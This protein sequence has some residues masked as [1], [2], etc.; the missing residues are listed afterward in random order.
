[1]LSLVVEKNYEAITIQDITE[2][3]DLNRA[4]FYLHY[5]SKDELLVESLT[6]HFDALVARMEKET[7]DL[8]VWEDP[9]HI[10][11]VFEF[12]AQHDQLFR[13]LLSENGLGYVTNSIIRYIAA[14]NIQKTATLDLSAQEIPNSFVAWHVAGSLFALVNWW[15]ENDMPYPPAD[16]AQMAFQLC[17]RGT[18]S[19]LG[20]VMADLPQLPVGSQSN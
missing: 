8:N 12:V 17:T 15:L 5:G 7:A 20:Q 11:L 2:R 9:L 18:Y 16:M 3:A 1:M 14:Y 4:T 6:A 10:Q 13:T 19:V